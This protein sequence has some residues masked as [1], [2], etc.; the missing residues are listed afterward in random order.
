MSDLKKRLAKRG[1]PAKEV[2]SEG[3]CKVAPRGADRPRGAKFFENSLKKGEVG[4][5][6]PR[7]AKIK[8]S[9]CQEK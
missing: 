8:S 4:K 2:E 7:T 5:A 3:K 9:S 1:N 6:I